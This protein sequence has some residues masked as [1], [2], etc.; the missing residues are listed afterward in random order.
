[1]DAS[2]GFELCPACPED[3][4]DEIPQQQI[5]GEFCPTTGNKFE[6]LK[7]YIKRMPLIKNYEK[8]ISKMELK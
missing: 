6:I 7:N 2:E 5:A 4:I 1:M 3:E 8:F